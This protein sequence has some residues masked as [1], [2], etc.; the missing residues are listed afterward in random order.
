MGE[1]PPPLFT[2]GKH[3]SHQ[4]QLLATSS[5]SHFLTFP[6]IYTKPVISFESLL[7]PQHIFMTALKILH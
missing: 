1:G 5:V 6:L 2:H 7:N 3:R 4:P